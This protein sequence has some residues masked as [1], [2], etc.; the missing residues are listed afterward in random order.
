MSTAAITAPGTR[1]DSLTGLQ[2]DCSSTTPFLAFKTSA[3][4]ALIPLPRA[5]R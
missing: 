2:K 1:P 4:V 5:A 3:I